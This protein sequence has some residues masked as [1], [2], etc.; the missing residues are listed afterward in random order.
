MLRYAAASLITGYQQYISPYK[1]FHCAHLVLHRGES[2]SV[3]GKRMVLERGIGGF[4]AAMRERFAACR[5]AAAV[6]MRRRNR[7]PTTASS[8]AGLHA[9]AAESTDKRDDWKRSVA[10][11]AGCEAACCIGEALVD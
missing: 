10:E 2:C 9:E 4:L 6:L 8:D 11:E 1:G 3:Y 5:R 7:A